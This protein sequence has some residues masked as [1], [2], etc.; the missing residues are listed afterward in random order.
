[1]KFNFFK[2]KKDNNKDSTQ[3]ARHILVKNIKDFQNS[4]TELLNGNIFSPKPEL[5]QAVYTCVN[6]LASNLS[7]IPVFIWKSSPKKGKIKY[8]T[9]PLYNLLHNRP[10]NYQNFQT[11]LSTLETVRNFFGNSFAFIERNEHGQITGFPIVQ[12][13]HITSAKIQDG[14]LWY[15]SSTSNRVYRA[16]DLLHFKCISKNG[17]MGL[18]PISALQTDINLNSKSKTVVDKFYSNNANSQKVLE[19]IE[20]GGSSQKKIDEA[21]T[22]FQ[23]KYA[24]VNNSGKIV[25]P[26]PLTQIKE[27]KLDVKNQM[28]LATA[29]FSEESIAALFSIPV[30][31]LG[32]KQSKYN[33][34]EQSQ[35]NFIVNTMAGIINIYRRELEFKLLSDKEINQSISIEFEEKAPGLMISKKTCLFS[36][37][38]LLL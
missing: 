4:Y 22:I 13:G 1:M 34:F 5:V 27:L 2:S 18:N 24:G 36:K 11:W 37:M 21:I 19:Q 31:L 30:D 7:R 3:E 6:I 38:S 17:L 29:Q 25:V 12:P 14:M 10:T 33:S 23:E 15:F 8:K 32:H 35:L 20:P 26:P 9:H 16:A 28:F